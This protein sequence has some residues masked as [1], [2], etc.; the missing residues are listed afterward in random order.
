M[1]I[2]VCGMKYKD[3]LQAVLELKPDFLGFNFY[4]VSP[5]F[6][7][8]NLHTGD[9]ALIPRSIKKV[10]IFV[11]Q[12]EYEIS[13]IKWKYGLDYIQLHGNES[14]DVCKNLKKSGMKII[15]AFRVDESFD[16]KTMISYISHCD[17]FLFDTP[18]EKFGGTGIK[19]NWNLLNDYGLGHPF[20]LSGGIKPGGCKSTKGFNYSFHLWGGYKQWV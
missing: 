15:K 18:S 13:G 9:L 2:K 8:N 17:F 10:G 19:F 6:V 5:R 16:E 20:F 14:A 12:D 11:N 3:N 1:K 7:E 4:P